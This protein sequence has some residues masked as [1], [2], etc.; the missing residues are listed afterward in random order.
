[1][2]FD[3][4]TEPMREAVK[5]KLGPDHMITKGVYCPWCWSVWI[6]FAFT[7]PTV[8]V[9]QAGMSAWNIFVTFL[10]VAFVGGYLADR[11][12]R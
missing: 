6:A 12:S 5:G 7:I 3:D 4:I 11:A 2:A 1:M 8:E 9:N 10:A